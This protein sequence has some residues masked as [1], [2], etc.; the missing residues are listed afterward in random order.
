VLL[1]VGVLYTSECTACEA[2]TLSAAVRVRR[3]SC[4][5]LN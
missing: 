2:G 5:E 3:L 1:F 4:A